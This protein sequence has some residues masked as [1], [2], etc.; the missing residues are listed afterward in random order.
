[1]EEIFFL[2]D[3]LKTLYFL[4]IIPRGIKK[5]SYWKLYFPPILK[6]KRE[7]YT[8]PIVI[9]SFL[10]FS[11][12]LLCIKHHVYPAM[13][14]IRQF[15]IF[16]KNHKKIKNMTLNPMIYVGVRIV[17]CLLGIFFFTGNVMRNWYTCYI[18]HMYKTSNSE[19]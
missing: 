9:E 7:F 18:W 15:D 5:F 10:L 14:L 4:V 3:I 16:I 2:Q 6:S 11:F 12:T 1:M 19:N 13:W 8:N 17:F